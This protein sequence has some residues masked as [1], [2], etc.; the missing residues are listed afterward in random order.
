MRYKVQMI[1]TCYHNIIATRL[2]KN[3]FHLQFSTITSRDACATKTVGQTSLFD[4]KICNKQFLIQNLIYQHLVR[5]SVRDEQVH[6][7]Y[8][9]SIYPTQQRLLLML[10]CFYE[11]T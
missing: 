11:H 3:I 2:M 4:R 10:I 1:Y 8:L 7:I 5:A 9:L 6:Q